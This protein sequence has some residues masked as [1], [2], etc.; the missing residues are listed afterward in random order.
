MSAPAAMLSIAA[1]SMTSATPVSVTRMDDQCE[2]DPVPHEGNSCDDGL[3]CTDPDECQGGICVGAARDCSD[4]IDCT[5]DDCDEGGDTCTHIPDDAV[6]D[7]GLFCDGAE[8]CD[9]AQGCVAGP[10]PCPDT[11]GLCEENETNNGTC[12]EAKYHIAVLS[13]GNQTDQVTGPWARTSPP[14][15]ETLIPFTTPEDP[16][17][18]ETFYVEV[19]VTVYS[20]GI[21]SAAVDLLYADGMCPDTPFESYAGIQDVWYPIDNVGA[22]FDPVQPLGGNLD[23]YLPAYTRA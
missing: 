1:T 3:F 14:E 10:D 8:V 23:T 12:V 20:N 2:A 18:T 21:A 16:S 17:A 4:A 15:C 9:E 13:E 11:N 22:P 6:C 5:I 7:N 19:W